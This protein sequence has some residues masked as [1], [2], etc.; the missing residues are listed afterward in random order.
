MYKLGSPW[1]GEYSRNFVF[2]AS[3]KLCREMSGS[4]TGGGTAVNIV[5]VEN[6]GI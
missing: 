3:I 4:E 2:V 1:T 5:G 6:R